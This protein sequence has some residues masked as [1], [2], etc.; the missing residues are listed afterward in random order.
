MVTFSRKGLDEIPK[1]T[2]VKQYVCNWG[3]CRHHPPRQTEGHHDLCRRQQ[4]SGMPYRPQ[5]LRLLSMSK[6]VTE[7]Q[8]GVD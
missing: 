8:G 5:Q 4:S 3:S 2:L 7:G 1:T 6:N